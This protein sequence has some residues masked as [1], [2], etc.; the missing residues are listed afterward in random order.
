AGWAIFAQSPQRIVSTA[1]S[2]T[3]LLYA[4]GL[5]DRV[6]GVD[7][8]S[9]YPP[10]ALQKPKIGDYVSPNLEAIAALKPDLVIIQTNPVDLKQRLEG[11][12]LKVLE[13]DQENIAAVYKSFQMVGEATGAAMQVARLTES[14]RGQLAA[15]AKSIAGLKKTRMMFVVGRTPNRLEDLIV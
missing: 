3:E 6:V 7:R 5:G 13:I 2:I 8:F 10:A 11:L 15:I 14:V 12:K 9:R 4:L 1:P